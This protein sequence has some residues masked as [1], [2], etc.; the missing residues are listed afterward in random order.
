MKIKPAKLNKVAKKIKSR[1]INKSL[2]EVNLVD[3]SI[4]EYL[5]RYKGVQSEIV[6]TTRF[7]KNSDLSTTCLEKIN[8]T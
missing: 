6:D 3:R 7:D 5:D 4:E 2:L 1:N 8:M